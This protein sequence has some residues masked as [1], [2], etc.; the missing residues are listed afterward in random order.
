MKSD[1]LSKALSLFDLYNQQD[2]NVLADGAELVPAEYFF[3]LKVY[4]WVSS[5]QP[6]ASE[7]LLLASRCQH[8]GRWEISRDSYPAGKAGYLRWRA[9]LA[10]Y[11]ASVAG[12]LLA[13]AGYSDEEIAG[14]QRILLKQKLKQD[15]EVQ[16][17]ENAL[18]LV[19]LEHQYEYFLRKHDDQKMI[20]I[21]QKTWA[22]MS[23]QGRSE[24]LKM[25]F[26]ERGKYLI[27]KAL[28]G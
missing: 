19:F 18:C 27:E 6:G 21:L 26:S 7:A 13:E 4:D 16:T 17:M 22:K 14:V 11:H 9:D 25:K 2:P 5:L 3:S 28:A 23:E 15:D 10:R 24:A 1:K 8:I 12:R 20:R